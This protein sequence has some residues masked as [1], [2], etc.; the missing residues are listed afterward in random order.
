LSRA[1]AAGGTGSYPRVAVVCGADRH[2]S[3]VNNNTNGAE[4][5]C[6]EATIVH[7]ISA[8]SL[9]AKIRVE[10]SSRRLLCD[11]AWTADCLGGVERELNALTLPGGGW[12]LRTDAVDRLDTAGALLLD[13]F[14]ARQRQRGVAISAAE[15]PERHRD[16]LNLVRGD[17]H[18]RGA[19]PAPLNAVERLGKR[20]I[21]ALAAAVDL[22]AF[23]GA[24]TVQ[25]LPL[26]V[27]P[28][29]IRWRQ[30]AIEIRR[31]GVMALPIVG[32]LAF[33]IGVVIAYQGGTPLQRY[34][35]NIFIVELVAMTVLRE[36]AP[37]IT[38]IIVAGRTG[39]SYT[40]ELGTMQVTEEVD[41][42]RTMGITPFEML[43][44]PKLIGLLVALPLLTVFA[45]I[46]GLLG[47]MVVA[48]AMFGIS[49][50]TFMERMPLQL[51]DS[52]F[53][54]GIIKTPIFAAIITMVG[55]FQGF[56][57]RG[58][59][60]QVGRSTTASVVLSIFLVIVTDAVFSIVFN[61]LDL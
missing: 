44:L 47:G 1:R 28:H 48:D 2:Y 49:M 57:V 6:P 15:L 43:V 59:S 30:V 31:A 24:S 4:R 56:R 55:C 11:G 58:S 36:M 52:T 22:L 14:I 20:T 13:R 45:D 7:V 40:A 46:L 17:E 33:L 50:Q 16:L 19:V 26:L 53:W 18:A 10:P 60:E 61:M 27:R 54:V 38:A 41:A 35:A 3:E 12:T 8:P 5:E 21:E 32:L 9:A 23:V 51:P 25:L 37:M 34:G 29:R 42:L 39:S